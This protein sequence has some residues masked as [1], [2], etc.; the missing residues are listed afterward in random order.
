MAHVK[1]ISD[2]VTIPFMKDVRAV[3]M[4]LGVFVSQERPGRHGG[5]AWGGGLREIDA[6][7]VHHATCPDRPRDT[8]LLQ[9]EYRTVVSH[10]VL[11]Q[12]HTD[13]THANRG[14]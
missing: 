6:T 2:S 10:V 7:A 5:P 9:A 8:I 12:T 1:R 14:I 11:L 3:P 13:P 4:L